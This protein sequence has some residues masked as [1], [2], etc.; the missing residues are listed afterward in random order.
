MYR[1][2]HETF[3]PIIFW[4]LHLFFPISELI[5]NRKDM[6]RTNYW[7][8]NFLHNNIRYIFTSYIYK[9]RL[10]K[11]KYFRRRIL[12]KTANIY[13]AQD[14]SWGLWSVSPWNIWM[15]VIFR[16]CTTDGGL[17]KRP[18]LIYQSANQSNQLIHFTR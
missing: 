5:M 17:P 9:I 2:L 15:L 16:A 4:N 14:W 18:K 6:Q 8:S 11:C 10:F 13:M 7:R 12:S 3:I 1:C